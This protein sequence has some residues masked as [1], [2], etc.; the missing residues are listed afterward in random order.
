METAFHPLNGRE[1]GQKIVVNTINGLLLNTYNKC[2]G[3]LSIV[4]PFA[5]KDV[6]FHCLMGVICEE[7]I[8]LSVPITKEY[9]LTPNGVVE[10]GI[11]YNETNTTLPEV[12]KKILLINGQGGN[13][14]NGG[15]CLEA[16]NDHTSY[17]F[18]IIGKILDD[19]K[20]LF[21]PSLFDRYSF[22]VKHR[23]R[24]V[25]GDKAYF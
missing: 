20:D 5:G 22:N 24:F 12:L 19:W 14:S 2:Q 21:F 8:K 9:R 1:L 25:I 15:P 23:T 4:R 18:T 3:K 6:T 7:A 11:Y 10:D 13:R 16:L 17:K